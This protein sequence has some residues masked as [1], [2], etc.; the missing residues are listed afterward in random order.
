MMKF[1]VAEYTIKLP[2]LQT[3]SHSG[4]LSLKQDINPFSLL[5]LYF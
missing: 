4:L 1:L 2:N 5:F 3:G